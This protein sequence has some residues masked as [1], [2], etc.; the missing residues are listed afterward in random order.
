M[1]SNTPTWT[2]TQARA[3]LGEMLSAAEQAPQHITSRGKPVAVVLSASECQRLNAR[4]RGPLSATLLRPGLMGDDEDLF[5]RY[6][7]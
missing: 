3:R 5:E 4:S 6:R 7:D 2:M 1:P